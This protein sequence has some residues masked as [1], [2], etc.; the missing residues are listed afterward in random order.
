[1]GKVVIG[2]AGLDERGHG[3]VF[4]QP[5]QRGQQLISCDGPLRNL[6]PDTVQPHPCG[7]T[8]AQIEVGHAAMGSPEQ[9]VVEFRM[10]PADTGFMRV[11]IAGPMLFLSFLPGGG[12]RDRERGRCGN[13][14]DLLADVQ[15]VAVVESACPQ[16]GG[17][18]IDPAQKVLRGE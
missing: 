14:V 1:M 7:Q 16:V 3:V 8:G 15:L 10:R 2:L 6:P 9:Q 12:G 11:E 17:R 13:P 18:G 4:G 5:F